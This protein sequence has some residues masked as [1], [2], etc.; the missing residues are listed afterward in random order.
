M[1]TGSSI[2]FARA[3]VAR[4]LVSFLARYP[5][6]SVE[7]LLRH[8]GITPQLLDDPNGLLS[9]KLWVE[10]GE[11]AAADADDWRSEH[12]SRLRFHGATSALLPT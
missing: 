3:A 12:S 4:S 2:G 11:M 5:T 7:R 1:S 9:F 8:A 10:L 6:V